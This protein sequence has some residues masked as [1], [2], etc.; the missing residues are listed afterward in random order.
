MTYDEPI[1][2]RLVEAAHA[3]D[4]QLA[5]ELISQPPADVDFRGT[6]C[7]KSRKAEVALNGEL[8][9]DVC[10]EFEEFRTDVTPLFAAAHNG[11]L[12]LV[13]ELL[14]AGANVNQKLFRGYATTA[15]VR[16][17]HVHVLELLLKNGASQASCEEA[18]LEASCLG[19]AGPVELLMGSD[20]ISPHVA[21][22]ALVTASGRGFVDFVA[23]LVENGVN[24]NSNARILLQSSKPS[25]YT[26]VD[27]NALVAAIV[28]RQVSIVQLLLKA[29]CRTDIK[30]KLGAWS[31]DVT[32][33]EEFRV[34]AGLAEPYTVTWCAVEYFE[35][36]GAIL[37][38]LL[39]RI[40]LNVPHL[41]RTLIHHA[42]LCQN[43]R[44]LDV[45]LTFG[46]DVES[47]IETAQVSNIRPVHLAARLGSSTILRLLINFGCNPNSKTRFEET[48]L[49]ICTRQKK[50]ECLKI[51]ASAGSDFGLVNT[52]G[53]DVSSIAGSVKWTAGFQR[54]VLDVIRTGKIVR[55]SNLEVFSSLIFAVRANDVEAL[56][57][58]VGQPDLDIDEKD[59]NGY[60]AVMVAAMNGHV[61]AFKVLINAG[62]DLDVASK[63]GET[64]LTLAKKRLDEDEFTKISS[65]YAYVK[66]RSNGNSN[67]SPAL[68][69][70]ARAGDLFLVRELIGKGYDV[71]SFD[72]DG[73]TPLMLAAIS[74]D[75]EMCE[76]LISSGARL[77]VRNSRNETALSLAGRKGKAEEALLDEV[78]RELVLRGARV[79]KHT[80][81][82]KGRPHGKVLRMVGG[83]GV[84][85]WGRSGKRK[86]VCRWAEVGP[87]SGF[88]WNRR[89]KRDASG[90]P[91]VFRVVTTEGREIHFACEEGGARMA[92]LWV[93]GIR[94]VTR[95]AIFGRKEM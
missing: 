46:A 69:R 67:K 93:R 9:S 11:N 83:S 90:G 45:L 72:R 12:T 81:E 6:V 26:N 75:R 16:E 89:M 39:H 36:S 53:E 64:G 91:G 47:P 44:A 94:L 87:S 23:T 63:N 52:L 42:I 17:G 55:S 30:V 22:H 70:A 68:H 37:R 51:L 29:G 73:Y 8:A 38:A 84:L 41:G 65:A 25:L 21:V 4:L 62:A 19:L 35:S 82:G 7:L 14:K 43:P 66:I 80:R 24:L 77:D 58:L 78:A 92:E 32:T 50:A 95:E 2:H 71:N 86:V 48:A 56:K 57:Q 15:A 88:R 18:L 28:N 85:A 49:M 5:L 76:L 33:G 13:R 3:D 74:D 59:G 60:T 61:E 79:R 54:A 1:S 10:V 20:L 40:S 27:C 34:G 31:W